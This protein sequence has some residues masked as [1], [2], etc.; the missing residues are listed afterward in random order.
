M[1]EGQIDQFEE[2]L[3]LNIGFTALGGE[4]FRLNVYKQKGHIAFV[5]RYIKGEIPNLKNLNLPSHLGE[6]AMSKHGLILVVGSTGSGK[7]TTL[8]SM[9]DYRNSHS[10][11]HILT[12]EDPI[13][14]VHP[15]K[16]SIVDQREVGVDTHSFHNALIN[17]MREA[18]DVILVGEIRDKEAMSHTISYAKSGH[19][20]LST[21][22]AN[23]C[24]QAL[25]RVLGFFPPEN[26]VRILMDLSMNL[27]AI[28]CQRLVVGQNM[29]RVAA[30][31]IMQPTPYIRELI[32]KGDLDEIMPA[33]NETKGEKGIMT[34]DQSLY[35]LFKQG[36]ISEEEAL[37]NSDANS[38][39]K[40]KLKLSQQEDETVSQSED[41]FSDFQLDDRML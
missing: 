38:D 18:P 37:Y 14:Y 21:L 36:K 10:S 6:I 35:R 22:H 12:I 3:E 30:L 8:A 20:C 24:V 5:V 1:S 27:V 17:A 39:L 41:D 31:E 2:E 9:I 34:F 11:G 7:S 25:E 23:N 13:E 40:L 19:L 28:V 29:K 26:H 4:R 15:Y 16:L 33:M 32:E